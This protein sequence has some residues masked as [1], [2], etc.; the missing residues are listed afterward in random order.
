MT[1]R[2]DVAVERRVVDLLATG[3][4]PM[5]VSRRT[6]VSKSKV[7]VM[8]HRLGGVYRPADATYCDRY[9]DRDERY[10]IARLREAGNAI[11]EIARMLGR[12][13]ATVSRELRRNVHESTGRYEPERA[14]RLAW[15]RQRRPKPSKLSQH[16]RLREEVQSRLDKRWSPDQVAGRLK[17]DFPDDQDMRISG[18]SIY[19]S[20]YVY[21]RGEPERELRAQLRR[22]RKTR[23]RRGR[24]EN[25]GGIPNPTPNKERP[26]EVEGRLVPG[27]HEGD[28]IM[29]S[30][31]SNSAVG[32][33]VERTTSF[34]TLLHLPDGFGAHRVADAVIEQM[35]ELPA[36]FVRTLTWD[37]GIEMCQHAKISKAIDLKCFFADP[38]SPWQRGSNE[39]TNGLLREYLPKGTDLSVHTQQDLQAVADALNDRPRKRLGYLTPREVYAKLSSDHSNKFDLVLQRSPDFAQPDVPQGGAP[40]WIERRSCS[41][42]TNFISP[43]AD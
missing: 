30:K 37:R 8:H 24:K 39:N 28:L 14:D 10:E 18:E 34:V 20:L 31:A 25:R 21:P 22:G 1:K 5:E 17:V 7:Y 32:T 4:G 12:S 27:H 2:L 16:P 33:I 26:A 13:P 43:G 35:S 3:I 40:P 11:R 6:G 23:K 41:L 15:E 36:W 9:L 29:G 19:L 42:R 38:Y